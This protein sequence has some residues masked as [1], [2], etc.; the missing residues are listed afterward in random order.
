MALAQHIINFNYNQAI[1]KANELDAAADKLKTDAITEM[2]S[3]I[4]QINHNWTGDNATAYIAKC[5][6]EQSKL[7]EI[8]TSIRNTAST[9]RTMAANIK[10]AEEE[11]L[12]IAE[13]AAAAAK[14]AARQVVD[15]VTGH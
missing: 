15:T 1:D 2:D 3:I 14:A 10:A 9:I 7:V 11:A 13:E 8:A 5:T 6:Q 12:R 4:S